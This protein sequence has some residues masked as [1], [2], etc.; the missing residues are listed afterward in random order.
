MP[1]QEQVLEALK[2][3]RF[4]GLSRDIVSFGFVRDIRVEGANVSFTIIT[5]TF[6]LDNR[7]SIGVERL[8]WSSDY[9]H[10]GADWPHSW[11]TINHDY[12]RI[13]RH[14]RELI[15]A[16]NAQRLYGFDRR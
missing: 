9:P 16:G 12:A 7:D 5:D 4:P 1:T 8:L 10:M 13:P 11:R 14:E 6:A 15:L 3:V 2:K